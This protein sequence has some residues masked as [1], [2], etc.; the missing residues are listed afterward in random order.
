[1]ALPIQKSYC[2][3]IRKSVFRLRAMAS[4]PFGQKSEQPA[5][6]V[7]VQQYIGQQCDFLRIYDSA[8]KKKF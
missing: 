8:F 2:N 5:S 4:L 3:I 7:S 1:M 6:R